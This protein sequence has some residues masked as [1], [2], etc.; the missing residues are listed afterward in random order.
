MQ[1]MNTHPTLESAL[2]FRFRGHD[3]RDWAEWHERHA[4]NDA[5]SIPL[6]ATKALIG[7]Q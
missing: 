5:G 3:S 2:N 4:Y 6:D 1:D 7:R